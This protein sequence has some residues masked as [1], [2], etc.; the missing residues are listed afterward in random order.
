MATD[1][2]DD[3]RLSAAIDRDL[4]GDEVDDPEE[5]M[6]F[7]DTGEN[8]FGENV[9]QVTNE[10]PGED[11]TDEMLQEDVNRTDSWLH[12]NKGHEQTGF[13]PSEALTPEN[14]DQLEEAYRVDTGSGGLQT[15]T[16]IVPGDG[17][18]PPVMYFIGS[19]T[20][21]WAV[22]ARTGEEYWTFQWA[23]PEDADYEIQ[24]RFRGVSVYEDKVIFGTAN[25]HMVALNRYTGEKEWET[26]SMGSLPSLQNLPFPFIGY[27]HSGSSH[28]Y[29]GTI[30]VG[31]VG[32]DNSLM[33]HTHAMALNAD[34]GEVEWTTKFAPEDEWLGDLWKHANSSPW[35]AA[36]I[37]PESDTVIWNAGNPRPMLNPMVRPGPNQMS[38]GV[39][40]LDAKTGEV[41]WNDQNS[42]Q[43]HWDY[44]GQFCASIV[45]VEIEGEERRAVVY[46]H[47]N[48]WVYVY[49]IED[50]QLLSRSEPYA[51][52]KNIH[53]FIGKGEENST[54]V[55]P[56]AAG[57][58]NYP[59]DGVSPRTGYRYS[60]SQDA[61]NILW[62]EEFNYP[63]EGV[64]TPGMGTGPDGE[65]EISGGGQQHTIEGE[66]YQ[67]YVTATDL[68]TGDQ[69]WRTKLPDSEDLF[70]NSFVVYPGGTTP[71]AGGLVFSGSSGGH[72]Y[73]L[74]DENGD[75]LWEAD[76][77]QRITATPSVWEDQAEGA[78]FVTVAA[79]NQIVGYRA[80]VD[81]SA[82]TETQTATETETDTPTETDTAT[83][84]TD[85]TSTSG[86][87]FGAAAGAA[88]AAGAGY[89]AKKRAD[90]EDDEET[91]EE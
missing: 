25:L 1:N 90:D 18:T 3:E 64:G 39:V 61:G 82:T 6:N 27:S 83:E 77:G 28:V 15:T 35:N 71:T 7:I 31:Q 85:T 78:V 72:L 62:M 30:Y 65:D 68:S 84:A 70:N 86:P 80:D 38:A 87:G 34:T 91:D 9:R 4:L 49:D 56:A 73:A 42:P 26:D 60:G 45:D 46:E 22:N 50:G 75:I 47:K 29:D 12:F 51:K 88:G 89:A 81:L 33:G 59:A 66:N 58:S 44:D 55:W 76:T 53:S 69:A 21:V 54:E 36:A 2:N 79:G 67:A 37:D 16:T 19:D 32:G 40:A 63:E 17:D 20:K 57:A 48:G 24:P 52:Q 11:V 74:D 5:R 23:Y 43:D 41:K 14:I 13:S 10:V 8:A